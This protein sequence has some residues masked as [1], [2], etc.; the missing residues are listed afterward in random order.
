VNKKKYL[1]L[2]DAGGVPIS[3]KHGGAQESI[4]VGPGASLS[5][6]AKYPAPP[7]NVKKVTLYINGVAPFEDIPI[8]Q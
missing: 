7:E 8:S 4:V 6:W 5:T 1:L 3:A 2:T